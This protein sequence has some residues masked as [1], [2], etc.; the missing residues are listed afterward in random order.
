[1]NGFFESVS[2]G[3]RRYFS[4][5]GTAD[6]KRFWHWQLFVIAVGFLVFALFSDD[7]LWIWGALT[8]IPSVAI[9]VRRLRDAGIP[10][11]LTLFVL[12][13]FGQVAIFAMALAPTKKPL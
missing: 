4:L 13:P 8:L 7:A 2:E 5:T 3:F 9:A 6:R 12:L 10:V 1:M 11:W